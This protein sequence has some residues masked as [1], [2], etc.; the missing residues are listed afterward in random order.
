MATAQ[1]NRGDKRGQQMAITGLDH[2]HYTGLL[3]EEGRGMGRGQT[4]AVSTVWERASLQGEAEMAGHMAQREHGRGLSAPTPTRHTVHFLFLWA[5]EISCCAIPTNSPLTWAS[6]GG[7]LLF[8]ALSRVLDTFLRGFSRLFFT[9]VI[10]FTL[11]KRKKKLW[12]V[13]QLHVTLSQF[14]WQVH[15]LRHLCIFRRT[16][17]KGE[18]FTP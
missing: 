13:A 6:A 1:C 10:V 2:P 4:T 14:F 18:M 16:L 8:I 15:S 12:V 3:S 5:G 7:V 9:A 11:H 17:F